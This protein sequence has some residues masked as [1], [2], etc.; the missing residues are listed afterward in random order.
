MLR[1][2]LEEGLKLGGLP[3]RAAAGPVR[4]REAIA[5]GPVACVIVD[6]EV[7]GVDGPALVAELTGDPSLA[8]VPVLAFAGHTEAELLDRARAAG[9]DR[10][11][12]RGQAVLH[13]A[14]LVEEVRREAR[15]RA[16]P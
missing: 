13:P 16:A 2:R 11:V 15:A 8:G 5:E 7:A 9:A 1:T 4:L 10:V 14:R 6:L 12:A 3:L